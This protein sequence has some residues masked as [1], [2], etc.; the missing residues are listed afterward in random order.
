MILVTGLWPLRFSRSRLIIIVTGHWPYHWP[1][2]ITPSCS[3]PMIFVTGLWLLRPHAYAWQFLS[4]ASG[5]RAF[6]FTL[7]NSCHWPLAIAPSHLYPTILV[8]D[9]WPSRFHTHARQF[10]SLA[11]DHCILT[12][13]PNNFCHCSFLLYWLMILFISLTD[14]FTN[15]FSFW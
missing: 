4:L 9:L 1:L 15:G 12:L 14:Y 3:R 11:S 7:N 5:H 6:T 10:L 8:T 2:A 13:T